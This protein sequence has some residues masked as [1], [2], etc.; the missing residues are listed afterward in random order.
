MNYEEICKQVCDVARDAGA[1]IAQQRKH[2]SA[3]KIEYKGHQNMVSYVD[4][5]S[6]VMIV[7]ALR[8]IIPLS[9]IIG[10]EGTSTTGS[11][12]TAYTWII[13]P[14]DGTT[15]FIHGLPPYCVSI[16]LTCGSEVV[17]GVVYEINVGECFYAWQGS[18]AYLNGSPIEVSEVEAMENSLV[19]TGLAYNMSERQKQSFLTLFDY[20]NLHTHGARR[21]GSAASDLVYVAAGRAEGFYQANL[22][23]WDVAAGGFIVER[24]GGRVSDFH[25]GDNWLFGREIIA[26]NSQL[27]SQFATLVKDT[28]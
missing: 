2:F 27:Y 24:A 18:G 15:N 8:A 1:F 7:R 19:I 5:E 14:L 12:E 20:F 17:V 21:L 22:S 4:K 11:I 16:A 13:D 28:L 6:E 25:G 9:N 3:D 26:T 10:E 23:P